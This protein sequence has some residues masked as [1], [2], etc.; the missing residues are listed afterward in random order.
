M[1]DLSQGENLPGQRIDK[2]LWHAR[3]IKTRTLATHITAAGKVRV[4]TRKLSRASQIVRPGDVLTFVHG[5]RLRVL[6]ILALAER[7]GPAA[8]ASALYEDLAPV[9]PA[10]AKDTSA[11]GPGS[12][13]QGP[14]AQRPS[15]SG[16]PT[17]RDR[18]ALTALRRR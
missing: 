18:R 6:K 13:A 16:R 4:N 10:A 9:E 17:K 2:W 7:R 5:D 12:A 3:I 15:G 14:V 11:A 1:S 8:Q